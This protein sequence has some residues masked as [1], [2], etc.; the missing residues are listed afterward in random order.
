MGPAHVLYQSGPRW[1]LQLFGGKLQV[2]LLLYAVWPEPQ[3]SRALTFSFDH[4]AISLLKLVCVC[5]GH[6]GSSQDPCI[7]Y[8]VLLATH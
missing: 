1:G 4:D 7:F 8:L 3:T 6:Q 5:P 2:K